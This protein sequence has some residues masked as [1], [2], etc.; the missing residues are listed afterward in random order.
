MSIH[1][2]YIRPKKAY[3]LKG[4][5]IVYAYRTYGD[6]HPVHPTQEGVHP[7]CTPFYTPG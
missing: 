3:I 4:A 1:P 7:G 2:A 6:G 5:N